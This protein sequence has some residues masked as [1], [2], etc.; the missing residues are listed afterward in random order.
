MTRKFLKEC[1]EVVVEWV[2]SKQDD[3][4]RLMSD[5]HPHDV[6]SIQSY[7]RLIENESDHVTISGH[8]G[9]DPND[10][11]DD[12]TCARMT[13]PRIAIVSIRQ[14]VV[15]EILDPNSI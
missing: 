6:L 8:C 9:I 4:W 1:P 10:G 11:D 7:G 3:G 2:D 13:I 14:I 5:M 12:Q 15:G